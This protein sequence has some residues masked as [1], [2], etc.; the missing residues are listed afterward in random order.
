MKLYIKQ[1]LFHVIVSFLR[2]RDVKHFIETGLSMNYA[3][4]PVTLKV[5]MENR[6]AAHAP[7]IGEASCAASVP[8][9]AG[10]ALLVTLRLFR[11]DPEFRP[12]RAT[13]D[14][15]LPPHLAIKLWKGRWRAHQPCSTVVF[16]FHCVDYSSNDVTVT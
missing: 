14:G 6:P 12:S 10:S 4:L 11:P 2:N 13:C 3:L 9:A 1:K 7:A 16:L 8:S 15:H 5:L